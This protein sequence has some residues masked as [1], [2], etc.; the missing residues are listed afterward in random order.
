MMSAKAERE[1]YVSSFYR[2]PCTILLG[3]SRG[4]ST[5]RPRDRTPLVVTPCG[6]DPP[7]SSEALCL[8]IMDGASLPFLWLYQGLLGPGSRGL[9][10]RPHAN[11]PIGPGLS[12]H[13]APICVAWSCAY[14]RGSTPPGFVVPDGS[15]KE[16]V[17]DCRDSA[18]FYPKLGLSTFSMKSPHDFM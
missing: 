13:G 4:P 3:C 11:A 18:P 17:G 5:Y 14:A 1:G 7:S 16:T 2:N 6:G 10:C 9:A 8:S 12:R 15:S